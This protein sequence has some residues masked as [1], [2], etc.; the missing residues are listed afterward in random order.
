MPLLALTSAPAST[1]VRTISVRPPPNRL[2]QERIIIGV[3]GVN[4]RARA[5]QNLHNIRVIPPNSFVE[6]WGAASVQGVNVR[7]CVHQNLR[8]FRTVPPNRFVEQW[9]AASV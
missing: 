8:Y 1:R 2:I 9:V 4:V 7:A 5:H 6:Q 3:S